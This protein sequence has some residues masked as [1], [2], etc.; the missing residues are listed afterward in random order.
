MP[1]SAADWIRHD[2]FNDFVRGTFPDGGVNLFLRHNGQIEM[3]HRWDLD[4]DGDLDL[5]VGQ[6]HDRVENEDVMVYWGKPGGPESFL[7]ELAALQPMGRFLREVRALENGI[8]RLPSD[9]GGRS[10]IVDLNN[11][12]FLDLIFCNF[13]HNYSV[14]MNAMIYPGGEDGFR[15]DRRMTLPTLLG[16]AVAAADFN[17]DGFIDLAFANQGI[18][19]GERFGF[20]QHLESYLYW[21]GPAGFDAD[22]RLSLPTISAI[23]CA[24]DD[25]DGDGDVDLVFINN[26]STHKSVVLFRNGPDGFALTDP[27][28]RP[29][30]DPVGVHLI[31]LDE[32]GFP[33]MIVTH[34]DG[35]ARVFDGGADGPSTAPAIELATGGAVECAAADLDRDGSIDLVFPGAG[36]ESLIYMGSASGYRA[37][38]RLALPTR[39]AT[40]AVLADF[41]GNGWT[42]VF[43]ANQ[44]DE[45]TYDVDSYLYWN[46]PD[47]LHREARRGLAGFGPV[48]AS[49]ADLNRDGHPDLLLINR[50]S[51]SHGPVDSFIYHGNPKA[52]YSSSSMT[53]IPGTGEA[54]VTIADL[55]GNGYVDLV[56]PSGRIYRG[57][58]DGFT[59]KNRLDLDIKD[60]HGTAVGDLNRDGYLDLVISTGAAHV[61]DRPPVGVILWGSEDGYTLDNRHELKL[62]VRFCLSP[63]L[64]DLDRDGW[65]DLIF[66]DVDSAALDIF[67]GAPD[68]YTN[69]NKTFLKIQSCATVEVADLNR[70]G[71]LDL[72]LGGGWDRARHGRPTRHASLVWG[73]PGRFEN[74]D[75]T[76]LEAYDSLE[77]TVVDLN[78]DGHLDIVMTNYHAYTTRSI[79]VFVYWGGPD[80]R[81][82]EQR[83]MT[84]P[85][86]SS[87][88]LTVLDLNGD[89]HWDLVVFNHVRNGDHG[90]GAW[91]YWG[92]DG[93]W[94]PANRDWLPTFGPHFGVRYDVGNVY[95]R[96]M[97]EAFVSEATAVPA[98]NRSFDLRWTASTTPGTAIRF[99]VRSAADRDGL[100]ASDWRGANSDRAFFDG[101]DRDHP[102]T[103]PD[104]HRWFQYK[105]IFSTRDGGR[106]PVLDSVGIRTR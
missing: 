24:A 105:A 41:D 62:Q 21:N 65:L 19:G 49:A 3:L 9:G 63:R 14:D 22:N 72:I 8:T 2:R 28:R 80:N 84:L 96:R 104:S 26:N 20:D 78:R 35:R 43:F 81:Y 60:G 34:R 87:G 17:R 15:P 47:G 7:P 56:Y 16:A 29:G 30:G 94:S 103:I 75:V 61:P 33:E 88:A 32:D 48:S 74:P 27:E 85:A 70:D 90:T 25:V 40:D 42:D 46:G 66:G 93:E 59:P 69:G 89:D 55:D 58:P 13:I 39:H 99:Q 6:D 5:F 100:S 106:T 31:D 82:S 38:N 53:R 18:E 12:G 83:R 68:G 76:R 98:G 45:T 92:D 50:Y 44:R 79:P 4:N 10:E 57:G 51:G 36:N 1:S 23:D 37:A 67:W 97:T 73:G 91:I 101:S 54:V 95:D 71:W 11:D 52:H 77:Q 102:F 86:E 64:A